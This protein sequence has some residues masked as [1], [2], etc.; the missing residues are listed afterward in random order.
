MVTN[1]EARNR[2]GPV[3][4]GRDRAMADNVRWI[5]ERE[6]PHGGV[7]VLA[8][9][10][11]IQT[12]KSVAAVVPASSASLGMF[13]NSMIGDDYRNIGFTYNKGAMW[14]GSGGRIEL[15]PAETGSIDWAMAQVGLP[16]F[17]VN[18]GTMP[19]GGA[20]REWL[21]RPVKQRIQNF[22][23]EYNEFLSWD[24]LVFVDTITPSRLAEKPPDAGGR[25]D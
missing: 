2:P 10:A 14:D 11:H 1:Y 21:D 22:S 6:G 19:R 3:W 20:V 25:K 17:L 16:L 15:P 4:N 9:N 23:T 7:I 8:H 5:R 13:L 18:F 24:G 12:T